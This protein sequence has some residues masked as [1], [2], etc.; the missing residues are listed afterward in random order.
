MSLPYREQ[1]HRD[2]CQQRI[3][4]PAPEIE[5]DGREVCHRRC[6]R[7]AYERCARC[8]RPLCAEHRPPS[9]RRCDSCESQF[10]RTLSA[11]LSDALMLTPRHRTIRT[12]LSFSLIATGMLLPWLT[13]Q[14]RLAA[15][16]S[17]WL[18]VLCTAIYSLALHAADP[19]KEDR[20]ARRLQTHARQRFLLEVRSH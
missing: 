6:D 17:A 18:L 16:T 10:E 9:D 12:A 1:R 2:F 19:L 4:L 20:A 11:A 3:A 14:L 5:S 13:L 15:G 8:G 7:L